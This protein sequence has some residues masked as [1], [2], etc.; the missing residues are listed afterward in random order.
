M[1][2]KNT[3]HTSGAGSTQGGS[4]IHRSSTSKVSPLA[5]FGSCVVAVIALVVLITANGQM[6]KDPEYSG[7]YKF[8][9]DQAFSRFDES[10][11]QVPAKPATGGQGGSVNTNQ[12]AEAGMGGMTP[13][14]MQRMANFGKGSGGLGSL[15][16]SA[17]GQAAQRTA[18]AAQHAHDDGG[19]HTARGNELFRAGKYAEA[20]SEFQVA[21]QENPQRLQARHSLGDALKALGRNDEAIAMYLEVLKQNPQYFCCYTHIGDIEKQRNNTAAAEQSYA[22]AIEGYKTQIQSGGPAAPSGKFQ[23]AKLYFDLDRDLPQAVKLAEEANAASP[24]T[25]AY[26]QVLAQLYG[27][28][29][30]T[31]EAAA[32]YDELIKLA[33]QYA[34]MFEQ[35]KQQL[36][37]IGSKTSSN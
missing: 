22:K 27:K 16:R 33:P 36:A 30:R 35:Q 31:T 5:L 23:L 29:G 2:G 7:L 17:Q 14:E 9:L 10:D 11:R 34:Q 3:S 26:V 1:A 21:L 12:M 15:P 18:A 8:T 6:F 28:L 13:A 24:N 4:P 20:V 37:S 19:P 25:F 32:R